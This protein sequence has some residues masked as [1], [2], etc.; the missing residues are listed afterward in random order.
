MQN[1]DGNFVVYDM[2]LTR[3]SGFV[4]HTAGHPGAAVIVQNDGHFVVYAKGGY[5]MAGGTIHGDPKQALQPFPAAT[6]PVGSYFLAMEDDGGL[7]LYAGAGPGTHQGLI[8]SGSGQS[9]KPYCFR[10]LNATGSTIDKPITL[11]AE[12]P[13][14]GFRQA[15]RL[16]EAD[17]KGGVGF[18]FVDGECKK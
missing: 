14:N 3:A 1:E 18:A 8:W 2:L 5:G 6:L 7:R 12:T 17:K 10:I 11:L 9:T 4:S 15:N 16:F 13:V